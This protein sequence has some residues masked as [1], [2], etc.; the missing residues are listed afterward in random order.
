MGIKNLNRFLRDNCSASAI[1]KMKFGDFSGKTVV[2]DT[3]IYMY[4][5]MSDGALMENMYLFISILK[6]NRIVPIFIFD[7][8]PP[9]EKMPLLKQ[10]SMDKKTAEQKYLQLESELSNQSVD[11]SDE[12]KN[13]EIREIQLEMTRLKRRFIKIRNDDIIKVKSLMTSYGVSYYDAPGEA[14]VLCAY[15]VKT[16]KAWACISDDMDMFLYGCPMVIRNIS[17]MNQ[18]AILHD[19]NMILDDLEMKHSEFCEIMVLSGTDYD[20]HSRTNLDDTIRWFVEYN[21]YRSIC[22]KY[23]KQTVGFYIW[24]VKNTKY[25][26]DYRTLINNYQLFQFD[27]H[28]ELEDWKVIDVKESIPCNNSMQS[29]MENE[30]FVFC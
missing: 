18:T 26:K 16:N 20:I 23:K 1:R 3:S 9:P 14:D 25:I 24:L 15:F 6:T 27:F 8:K 17:L 2:I 5:F 13:E 19:M 29:I 10:R 21:K 4:K 28:K 12:K 7:G 30:G 22:A 11:L